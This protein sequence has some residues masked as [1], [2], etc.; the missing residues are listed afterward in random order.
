[1]LSCFCF[2]F[3]FTH[4]SWPDDDEY[5]EEKEGSGGWLSKLSD[6]HANRYGNTSQGQSQEP[7]DRD[8]QSDAIA[9]SAGTWEGA[10]MQA[11][12]SQNP[13]GRKV[14]TLRSRRPY[15]SSCSMTLRPHDLGLQRREPTLPCFSVLTR[16]SGEHFVDGDSS[17]P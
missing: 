17:G 15:Q 4:D 11:G 6:A 14:R 2:F 9:V 1:M 13:K 3:F 12:T 10:G 5:R 16:C 7:R 8:S